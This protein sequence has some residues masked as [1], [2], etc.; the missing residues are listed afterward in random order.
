[1]KVKFI[2]VIL[3][4]S[5][6]LIMKVFILNLCPNVVCELYL[7]SLGLSHL[8]S[9]YGDTVKQVLQLASTK[10]HQNISLFT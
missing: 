5:K 10:L 2:V 4:F 7:V 8:W 6:K 9:Q 1:M 3:L